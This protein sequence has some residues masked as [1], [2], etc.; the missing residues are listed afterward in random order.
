MNNKQPITATF[1]VDAQKS[2]TPLMPDELP[3]PGGDQIV[4]ALNTMALLGSVRIGSKDAHA[5]N[6]PWITTDPSLVATPTGVVEAPLFWPAHCVV[7]TKG[8]E[9]LDGLPAPESYSYFV[10]KGI[11]NN[12]HPFGAC[13]HD[14][15][16]TRT[17][18]VIEFL[19][20]KGIARVIVGGLAYD[21]CVKNTAL[22]LAKAGFEVIIPLEAVRAISQAT[23]DQASQ[24]LKAAGVIL[25]NTVADI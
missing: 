11:E 17:T 24:E 16:E 18:G 23:S 15:S 2:F 10:W 9:L 21:Y 22:Q 20:S 1:D 25:V 4:D 3:V 13:W 19:R 7:G 12:L 6:A 8:F 5:A 14:V